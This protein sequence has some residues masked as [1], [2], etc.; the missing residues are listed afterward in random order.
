MGMEGTLD[1]PTRA[2][3]ARLCTLRPVDSEFPSRTHDFEHGW[4]LTI[5]PQLAASMFIPAA[6]RS[7]FT[8][9]LTT[10]EHSVRLSSIAKHEREHLG[11]AFT[12]RVLAVS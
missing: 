3:R 1:D 12:V 9:T 4:R 10:D 7:F 11:Q 2:L 5:R 8:R 6:V